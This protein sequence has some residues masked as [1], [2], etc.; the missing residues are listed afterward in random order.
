MVA[1]VNPKVVRRYLQT[2]KAY[3]LIIFTCE[4]KVFANRMQKTRT[5][6]K[7]IE[8]LREEYG[9]ELKQIVENVYITA[10]RHAI[11]KLLKAVKFIEDNCGRCKYYIVRNIAKAMS[12]TLA[13]DEEWKKVLERIANSEAYSEDVRKLARRI[14]RRIKERKEAI[15]KS[16]KVIKLSE[17]GEI[18]KTKTYRLILIIKSAKENVDKRIKYKVVQKL[19][20]EL[21]EKGIE[22]EHIYQNVYV[23]KTKHNLVKLLEAQGTISKYP[24]DTVVYAGLKLP[25]KLVEFV[26]MPVSEKPEEKKVVEKEIPQDVIELAKKVLKMIEEK[27]SIRKAMAYRVN[28]TGKSLAKTVEEILRKLT[29]SEEQQ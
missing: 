22:L 7:V 9:I 8:T 4:G 25:L 13:L 6:K 12:K 14:V 5:I 24:L 29:E 16:G 1:K 15:T 2:R 3:L 20:K 21:K 26:E 11:S 23:S 18:R 27:P 19:V 17:K 28:G 10:K